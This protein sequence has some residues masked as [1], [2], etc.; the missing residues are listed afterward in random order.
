[1][2]RRTFMPL[3]RRLPAAFLILLYTPENVYTQ[4]LKIPQSTH[5]LARMV[6]AVG[7]VVGGDKIILGCTY[8]YVHSFMDVYVM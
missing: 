3:S 2:L 1:M 4:R 5:T 8:M 7:D 6:S